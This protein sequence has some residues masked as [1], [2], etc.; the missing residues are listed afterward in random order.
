MHF[1]R[2]RTIKVMSKTQ[3]LKTT[4]IYYLIFS[5]GQEFRSSLAQRFNLRLSHEVEVQ[6]SASTAVT[7]LDYGWDI[8]FRDHSCSC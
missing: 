8:C 2:A 3:C 5:M 7:W 6:M 4:N 1:I